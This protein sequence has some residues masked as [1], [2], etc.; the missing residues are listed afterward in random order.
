MVQEQLKRGLITKAELA[1]AENRNVI[2]RAVGI[3]PSVAVDTL[4]TDLL[5]GDLYL[6][7]TDGL[8]G[9]LGEDELPSLLAQEKDKLADLL[10][11]LALQRGG[12]DN[13]TAVA[14]SVESDDD[15]EP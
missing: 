14:L 10:V 2:T 3:Q 11:D 4:V 13:A 1:T 7:C 6:L 8:H 12:K 15:E 5:P 9:Y